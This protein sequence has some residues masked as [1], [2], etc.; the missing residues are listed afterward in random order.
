[1]KIKLIKAATV[2]GVRKKANAAFDVAENIANKLIER[3]YAALDDGKVEEPE[4]AEV[5]ENGPAS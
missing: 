1:M 3:G 2:E 4:V 5:D